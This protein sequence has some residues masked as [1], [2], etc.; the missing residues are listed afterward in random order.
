MDA[1]TTIIDTGSKALIYP[2]NSVSGYG[3]IYSLGIAGVHISAISPVTC[4]N[5]LSRYVGEKFVVPNPC[6]DHEAFVS[7]LIDYGKRQEIKPT[8]FMAEDLYA[9]IVSLYQE[10]LRPYFHFP[11]IPYEKLDI[12]FHK[13]SMLQTAAAA[14]ISIPKS[15]F[16]PASIEEIGEWSCFPAVIKP[17]ISRFVFQGR[18]LINVCGF[19]QLFGGKAVLASNH[20]ELQR[21][22][23]RLNHTDFEYCIQEYIPGDDPNLFTVYFVAD[24]FGNIPCFSTHYKVRQRPADFGTTSVS[25]SEFVPE[26]REYAEQFCKAAGYSGPA[27]M[28]FKLSENDGKWYLMEINPRLGFSIRRSTVKGVNMVLQQ[29]LFSTGQDLMKGRQRDDGR[30]WIDIPG[31][32]K[33]IVSHRG[34]KQRRL[35]VWNIVKPYLFFREAV[36]NL[37]DPVPGLARI[38]TGVLHAAGRRIERMMPVLRLLTQR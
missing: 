15:L 16:S 18:T 24:Q 37:K 30:C 33:A 21:C 35:S 4:A 7:W 22:I 3:H 11:Y 2:A 28:E 27:T 25:Q 36:F 12:L 20:E 17:A 31:D 34:K 26:L 23:Q 6:I 14:G 29:Y 10:E 1:M 13:R 9:Y 19:P 32:I 38:C 5:F 8:L